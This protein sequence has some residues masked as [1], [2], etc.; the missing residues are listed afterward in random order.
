MNIMSLFFLYKLSNIDKLSK[1][2]LLTEIACS[3]KIKLNF[4]KFPGVNLERFGSKI[5]FILYSFINLLII[6][7]L[8]LS[9]RIIFNSKAL[10]LLYLIEASFYCLLKHSK[11]PH[12][13]PL[14]VLIMH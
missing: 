2:L 10:T 9:P 1:K 8:L 4:K 7:I 3:L 5:V 13:V 11:F 6:S 12:W 14:L